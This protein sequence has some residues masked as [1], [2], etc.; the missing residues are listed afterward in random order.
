MS[1]TDE[2][3]VRRFYEEMCTGKHNEIAGELFTANCQLHDP[4]IKAGDGPEGMVEV[5]RT[6]QDGVDAR[7]DIEDVFSAGE[8]VVARW[9]GNGRHIGD[10][11]G[12]PATGNEVREIEGVSVHRMEGGKIAET[13]QVWDTYSFLRQLGVTQ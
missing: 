3:V 8:K 9:T 1:T 5:V 7:W 2:A 12:I 6:Y 10:V 11:N 13:W 4:Q